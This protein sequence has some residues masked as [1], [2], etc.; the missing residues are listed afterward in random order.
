M[1]TP[2]VTPNTAPETTP[3]EEV[4]QEGG[5][6]ESASESKSEGQ[7]NP[8]ESFSD[9]LKR[10]KGDSV[11]KSKESETAPKKSDTNTPKPSE[12]DKK[13]PDPAKTPDESPLKE[14]TEDVLSSEPEVK[15][16]DKVYKAKDIEA[17][18][19]SESDTKAAHEK[20][21]EQ[22]ETFV[23][24]LKTEPGRIFDKLLEDPAVSEVFESYLMKRYVEPAKFKTLPPEEKVAHY[25]KLEADRRAEEEADKRAEAETKAQA[26]AEANRKAWT[27]KFNESLAKA[28]L[29]QNEWTLARMAGYMK[30]SFAKGLKVTPD[31]VIDNVRSDLVEAHKATLQNLDPEQLA[32]A[33]G[34]E[35]LGKLRARDVEKLK[36]GKFENKNPGKGKVEKPEKTK[37]KLTSIYE[38]LD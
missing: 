26:D 22:V 21:L 23:T 14:P 11:S 5:V 10:Q 16:G 25:E 15:I 8:N 4:S 12:S 36:Q 19:K 6:Q 29:P 28:G 32:A 1:T 18:A 7:D 2:V 30:Q 27:D 20:T 9:W 33:L 35:T 3:I 38:L 13:V 24:I 17:L 34:E 37:K 31:D